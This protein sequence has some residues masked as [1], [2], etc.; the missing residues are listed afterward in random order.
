MHLSSWSTND[1]ACGRA[2]LLKED[3][4]KLFV[5]SFLFFLPNYAVLLPADGDLHR[6][7]YIKSGEFIQ[8]DLGWVCSFKTNLDGVNSF[9]PSSIRVG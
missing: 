2:E 8:V 7:F 6:A 1:P 4:K 9:K 5:S 3:L